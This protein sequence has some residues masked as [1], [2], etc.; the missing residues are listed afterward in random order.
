MQTLIYM[1][2]FNQCVIPRDI[3]LVI[4]Q[5]LY[6]QLDRRS[7]SPCIEILASGRKVKQ[8]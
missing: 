1:L 7:S 8:L 3:P 5:L 2:I 6:S 4:I